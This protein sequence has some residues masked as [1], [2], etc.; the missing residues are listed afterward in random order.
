MRV[1]VAFGSPRFS[2][3]SLEK[4]PDN[5]HKKYLTAGVL[6]AIVAAI[7]YWTFTKPW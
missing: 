5:E 4:R 1:G 7:F 2:E 6:L 3:L